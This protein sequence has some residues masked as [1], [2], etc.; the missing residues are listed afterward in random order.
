M[1]FGDSHP[2]NALPTYHLG[3]YPIANM[4]AEGA[5]A[6]LPAYLSADFHTRATRITGASAR[7][8][9]RWLAFLGSPPGI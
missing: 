1:Q 4:P 2:V 8:G 5:G 3:M 7:R 6:P 9:L